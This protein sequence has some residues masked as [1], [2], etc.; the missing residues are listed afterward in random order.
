MSKLN[1][2]T[3]NIT[4][5]GKYLP[6]KKLTNKDLEKYLETSDQWIQDRTGIKVRHI[7]SKNQ[8]TS[9][10]CI[11]A[12]NQLLDNRKIS[13]KEI[14]IIIVAT[15]TPDMMF[16]STACIIQEKIGAKN[17]WGFDL[18]GA[19]SGF[20]FALQTGAQ[21]IETGRYKKVL[22]IGADTMSSIL[23][24]SDRNTCILFGDG[25]GAALLE[26]SKNQY[27]ILDS[28]LRIDGTGGEYLYLK[29]GGS[30]MPTTID[31]INKD[32]HYLYQEGKTVFKH[33]VNGMYNVSKDILDRN[34]LSI[35]Q[36]D[37]FIP[38]QA[39]KRIIDLT[40]K[41]LKIPNEKVLINID[42]YANTTAAT[43]PL[44]LYDAINYKHIKKGDLILITVF[45]A[46]FTFGS[47]LIKW[48][49]E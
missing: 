35:N 14:D 15:V 26:P 21:F 40:A 46:G 9:D 4:G 38:H 16:P 33:A 34:N 32:Y 44:A 13:S 45:G 18:S 19:C 47:I 10:L 43:I 5:I 7:A 20:L 42:K 24:Y 1:R 3:A 23:N 49:N 8:A 28:K 25:A 11:N 36:I 30:R 2:I 22:V 29:A 12:I 6:E 31:T 37:L 27:G 17:A 39:N 48:G 41:R